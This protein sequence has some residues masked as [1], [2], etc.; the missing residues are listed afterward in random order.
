MSTPPDSGSR[1]RQINIAFTAGSAAEDHLAVDLSPA[2]TAAE[3]ADLLQEWWFLRKQPWRLRYLPTPNAELEHAEAAVQSLVRDLCE[4][5][6][7]RFTTTIY[8]PETHA[9]GG[10]A[11]MR[12][13]HT[14]FHVDSRNIATHLAASR[15]SSSAHTHNSGRHREM[16]LL[17]CTALMRTAGLDRYEQGDVWARVAAHRPEPS[18]TP[19]GFTSAV[20]ALITVDTAPGAELRTAGSLTHADEWFTAFER[21]GRTLRRLA[22]TGE[23][24]RGIRAVI[25]HHVLFHWNRMGLSTSDQAGLARAAQH[26]SFADPRIL[27]TSSRLST[28]A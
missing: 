23:L 14:L 18:T 15:T 8:E 21:T 2:L 24:T 3:D 5:G 19:E 1:W 20:Q 6:A 28:P 12:T 10:P 26:L 16:S 13:A 22:D 25:T 27:I 17:L 4:S 9:F 11:S 7:T